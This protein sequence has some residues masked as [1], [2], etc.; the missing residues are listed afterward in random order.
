MFFQVFNMLWP[1]PFLCRSVLLWL[2]VYGWLKFNLH[3]GLKTFAALNEFSS[4]I[5]QYFSLNTGWIKRV[6]P[7]HN[8][9]IRA[10]FFPPYSFFMACGMGNISFKKSINYHKD[11]ICEVRKML[12]QSTD[13]PKWAVGLWRF[14]RVTM[15]GLHVCHSF[16]IFRTGTCFITFTFLHNFLPELPVVFLG[17][18][19]SWCC[20]F[21]DI[22]HLH[23]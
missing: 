22:K 10:R 12:I 15:I 18:W 14:S 5:A 21:A 8:A 3:P 7:Q 20:L 16:Y 1:K 9:L 6:Y 4:R 19:L 23:L 11:Q 17:A 2:D 13:S